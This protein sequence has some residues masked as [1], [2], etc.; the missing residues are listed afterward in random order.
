MNALQVLYAQPSPEAQDRHQSARTLHHVPLR[1]H[2]LF[3]CIPKRKTAAGKQEYDTIAAPHSLI[4]QKDDSFW[5]SLTPEKGVEISHVVAASLSSSDVSFAWWA[6][7]MIRTLGAS[8]ILSSL[9]ATACVSVEPEQA[10]PLSINDASDALLLHVPSPDWRDQIIYFIMTDRFN[11]GDPSNNDQGVGAFDPSKEHYYSGGDIEGIIDELDYIQGLGATAVWATPLIYNQWKN[12]RHDFTGYGGY[13]GLNFSEIDPHNGTIET[14]QLLSDQLH[15]RG[16]YLIQDIVVNHSAF[17]FE[18]DETYN[19]DDTLS[20][21]RLLEPEGLAQQDRVLSPFDQFDRANADHAEAGIYNWTPAIT[22]YQNLGDKQFTHQLGGLADINTKNPVVIDV[23]KQV[24]GDWIRKAGVD[25]FRI[26]TVRYVEPSFFDQFMN[27]EDGVLAQARETGRNAFLTFGEVLDYSQPFDNAGE[28]ALSVYLGTD[29][30]PILSSVISFPL[31]QDFKTVFAQGKPTAHLAYRLEQHMKMYRTPYLSPT[32]IDNHD[33]ERFLASGSKA[34]FKQALATMFTVPGI[35]TI[36][37]GTAQALQETRQAMFKGGYL[38]TQDH[39]D[40]TTELYQFIAELARLR[41]SNTVLSRGAMEIT[42]SSEYGPGLLAFRRSSDSQ[43]LDILLNTSDQPL[44]VDNYEFEE[45]INGPLELHFS[46]NLDPELRTVEGRLTTILPARAI[47][48]ASQSRDDAPDQ[49]NSSA[50]RAPSLKLADAKETHVHQ[51]DIALAGSSHSAGSEI[52]L[53]KNGD[54]DQAVKVQTDLNGDWTYTHPVENLGE[55][56][57]YLVA[58]D[59]AQNLASD[60][61]SLRT[62]VLDPSISYSRDDPEGDDHGP[63][64][65]YVDMQHDSA[66][67]QKDLRGVS[68]IAGGEILK[69]ELTM[70]AVTTDWL[71]PNQ[72]DNVAFNIFFDL[73]DRTGAAFLPELNAEMPNGIDWDLAH[74]SYGWGNTTFSAQ[75]A[76]RSLAGERFGATPLIEVDKVNR[77]VTFTYKGSDYGVPSWDGVNIYIA[78]WDIAGEGAYVLLG[79]EPEDWAFGGGAPN[80]P[81][82]LDD[83]LIVGLK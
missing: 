55:E 31:K 69:L 17:L 15:R 74:I 28:R 51:S 36:Y 9:I 77:T 12:P 46:E 73:P 60:R 48:V 24:Y 34:G 50:A 49:E 10:E 37:Q 70:D 33:V 53:V 25:A 8:L 52:W 64:G 61:L 63:N 62:R 54:I 83:H 80:D 3:L 18:Y 30:D 42:G 40:Q 47:L 66:N 38:S 43:T 7:A 11:D 71:P 27:D 29:T 20:G 56:Y 79:P 1:K 65:T 39:F 32:L 76:T 21:F 13:Y 2:T 6:Y 45:P 44:L 78:T 35:P 16:M 59:P 26:D 19:A 67:G 23:F 58:Y 68:A 4:R 82:I 41:R 22:D 57:F 14:Y 72:F 81:R 75:G 5:Q